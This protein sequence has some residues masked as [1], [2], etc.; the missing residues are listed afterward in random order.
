MFRVEVWVMFIERLPYIG[1]EQ[2][3]LFYGFKT[4]LNKNRITLTC[5]ATRTVVHN[6]NDSSVN[7]QMPTYI[8]RG[9][10]HGSFSEQ[11]V[12]LKAGCRGFVVVVVIVF[13]YDVAA[14]TLL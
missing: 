7:A 1:S 13:L 2:L 8:N 6:N 5:P 14:P 11:C 10:L 12:N 3:R 9:H 4:G